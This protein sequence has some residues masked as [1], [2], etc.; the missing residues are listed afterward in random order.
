MGIPYGLD[1]KNKCNIHM[2]FVK[3]DIRDRIGY[4]ILNRLEKRN[5]LNAEFVEEIKVSIKSF[6]RNADIR[7]LILESSGD[8]F[9]AG[10]DLAYLQ[11]L[12]NFT[13]EENLADSQSLAELFKLIYAF[14]KPTLSIV[15]GAA[16]AGGCGLAFVC[17]FCFGTPDSTFGYTEV[18]IGFIPAIVLVFLRKK[19]GEAASKKMLFTGEIFSSE[20]ALEY[21]LITEIVDADKIKDYAHNWVMN[22]IEKSS[23]N[24]ISMIK[25]M[26]NLIDSL[27]LDEAIEYACEMNAKTRETEDCRKGISSF[28]TKQRIIW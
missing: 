1:F 17:D 12:Q 10:A 28:L 20:K 24:S 21:G 8:V 23:G 16:L 27:S 2:K 19:I 18:K 3:T 22:L 7:A 6:E 4:I 13:Y 5:A 15:N 11:K 14:P 26:Y 25:Q 9:C